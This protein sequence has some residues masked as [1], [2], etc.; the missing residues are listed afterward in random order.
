MNVPRFFKN[1]LVAAW[2]ALALCSALPSQAAHSSSPSPTAHAT[3]P[4][5]RPQLATG[6]TFD[7]EGRLWVVG[8]NEQGRLFT[9]YSNPDQIKALTPP[10]VLDQV[11]DTIAADGENHPKIAFGPHHWAVISYTKPLSKPYTGFIRMVRSTDAG[12]SFSAPFTLHQDQQEIAHRFESVIFDSEGTLHSLWIDKRD[13]IHLAG[14]EKY[15]GAAVYR[16]TSNDGGVTF[17]PDTKVADHSCEC[18]RISL[19]ANEQGVHALWRHVFDN[20]IRDHAF[21]TLHAQ[22]V[23]SITRA[24]QDDWQINACPHHG[25]GLA[26]AQNRGF[27][28]VWFGIRRVGKE[29]Q[30]AVRYGQL[31]PDGHPIPESLQ[32]LPDPRAEHA[33]VAA[34]GELVVIAWRSTEGHTST[35]KAWVS[36]DGGKSFKLH[37]LGTAVGANDHPR[38]AQ[39]NSRIALVWRTLNGLQIHEIR[40]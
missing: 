5:T 35:L 23:P 26:S 37:T 2:A 38:L 28:A 10:R 22:S 33:D 16:N 3:P 15:R 30:A 24:T 36:S 17:S 29:N 11:H 12:Q 32:T 19:I 39:S 25:P 7:R 1:D 21:A 18:C 6:A 34:I 9:Q 31:H 40:K 13:Q 8:V 4:T 14:Q 20:N 27:H